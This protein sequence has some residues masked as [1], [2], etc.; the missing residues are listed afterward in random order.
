MRIDDP[1]NIWKQMKEKYRAS[2]RLFTYMYL[3][4]DCWGE[5]KMYSPRRIVFPKSTP[6]G[7]MILLGVINLHAI[8]YYNEWQVIIKNALGGS[9]RFSTLVKQKR[10]K[11][12]TVSFFFWYKKDK[13]RWNNHV[14][15][16]KLIIW[17]HR[18]LILGTFHTHEFKFAW[19]L[20]G[21]ICWKTCHDN[22]REM[23]SFICPDSISLGRCSRVEWFLQ[24][25]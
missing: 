4:H 23:E 22:D 8:H 10:S 5:M 11:Y 25:E 3:L 6:E 7:N 12:L 14:F 18:L 13:K 17:V 21:W 16:F 20:K 1:Q 24:G 15:F 9:N 19:L 2:Y